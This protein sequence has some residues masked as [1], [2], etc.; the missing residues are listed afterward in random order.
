[1]GVKVVTEKSRA[2][3]PKSCRRLCKLSMVV[4]SQETKA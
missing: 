2:G 4:Q 3:V 1:M